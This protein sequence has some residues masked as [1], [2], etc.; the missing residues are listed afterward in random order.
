MHFALLIDYGATVINPYLAFE[1]IDS[2]INEELYLK[3]ILWDSYIQSMSL[4]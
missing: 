4:C 3:N 1:T 2:L